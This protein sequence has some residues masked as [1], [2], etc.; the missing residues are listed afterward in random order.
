MKQVFAVLIVG[1]VANAAPLWRSG[2]D[3]KGQREEE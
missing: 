1:F 3:A 2:R